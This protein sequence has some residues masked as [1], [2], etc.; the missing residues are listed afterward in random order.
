VDGRG[1]IHTG[2]LGYL[3]NDC[4]LFLTHRAGDVIIRGSENVSPEEVA[5]MIHEHPAVVQVGVVRLDDEQWA[6]PIAAVAVLRNGFAV[7]NVA[8]FA[9]NHLAP[10][11]RPS[12]RHVVDELRE[13]RQAR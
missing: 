2:D 11:K 1:W 8:S 6:E 5:A 10:F 4:S 9:S 3:D 12:S 13:P 7:A